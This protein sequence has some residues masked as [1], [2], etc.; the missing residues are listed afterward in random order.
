[1]TESA[2][3]ES[4]QA[5]P[6]HATRWLA[7]TIFCLLLL[8]IGA[9]TGVSMFEQFKAQVTHLQ[10]KLKSLPQ[11][12]YL[13]V[14]LDEKNAPAQLATFD[15]QDGYVQIQRLN[16]VTEGREESLQLWSLD[17]RGQ[18][19]ALGIVAPKLKTSQIRVTEKILAQTKALVISVENKGGADP[20]QQPN[21]PYLFSGTVIQK[22]L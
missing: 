20:G 14:L 8:T 9:A 22:A 17:E 11:I 5:A 13:A 19:L 12:K 7:A 15:P 21:Q 3:I 1:M 16:N 6:C 18:A 4:P 2:P 10:T